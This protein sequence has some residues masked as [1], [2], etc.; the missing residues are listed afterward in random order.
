MWHGFVSFIYDHQGGH[1][2]DD[3]TFATS[4]LIVPGLNKNQGLKL[5]HL[6]P[7]S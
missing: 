3:K 2:V 1:R 7:H 5:S 4:M 6:I